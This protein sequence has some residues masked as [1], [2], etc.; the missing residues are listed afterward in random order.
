MKIQEFNQKYSGEEAV[1]KPPISTGKIK[2]IQEFN[3]KYEGFKKTE[4]VKPLDEKK[5]V[6]EPLFQKQPGVVGMEGLP[7]EEY[8]GFTQ[9]AGGG[10]PFDFHIATPKMSVKKA[11]LGLGAGF[12]VVSQIVE[13]VTNRLLDTADFGYDFVDK[14]KN[15][16]LESKDFVKAG[17]KALNVPLA[18]LHLAFT[19]ISASLATAEASGVPIISQAGFLTNKAFEYLGMAGGW[20][21][22]KIIEALPVSDETKKIFMEPAVEI[23]N[24]ALPLLVGKLGPKALQNISERTKIT[25][26]TMTAPEGGKM[27]VL[28]QE[29]TIPAKI[30]KVAAP[31]SE[32]MI[33]PFG[34]TGRAIS[35][36]I[37]NKVRAYQKAGK[38]VN[39]EA[40]QKIVRDAVREV[41]AEV[42]G[43]AEIRRIDEKGKEAEPIV[44]DTKHKLVLQNIIP[45][46]ED[47]NWKKV[48]DL[49]RDVDGR[50]INARYEFD[51]KNKTGTILY[52][53]R[54]QLG[55]MVH[56]FGHHFDRK[57][58]SEVGQKFSE[59]LGA[60][61]PTETN[62]NI[63]EFVISKLGGSA[64]KKQIDMQARSLAANFDKQITRLSKGETRGRS[65]RF[66]EAVS[67]VITD[68]AGAKKR[69]PEFTAFVEFA[70]AKGG[71]TA[72]KIKATAGKVKISIEAAPKVSVQYGNIR[73]YIMSRTNK[74]RT[75]SREE[76]GQEYLGGY[77]D[78]V[79]EVKKMGREPIS[80]EQWVK[81]KGIQDLRKA[82]KFRTSEE[83]TTKVLKWIGDRE[84]V[85][86][87]FI[88]DLTNRPELK[89]VER[90]LIRQVLETYKIKEENIKELIPFKEVRNMKIMPIDQ[91]IKKFDQTGSVTIAEDKA[92]GLR[93]VAKDEGDYVV[94]GV[95]TGKLIDTEL[96]K[97]FPER[98]FATKEEAFDFVRSLSEK[99]KLEAGEEKINAKEFADKVK[100]ELLPLTVRVSSDRFVRPSPKEAATGM[101]KIPKGSFRSKHEGISLPEEV[102]GN[103]ANYQERIYESPIKTSAGQT[104][105]GGATENYFG[106]TRIEDMGI[107]KTK[108][109]KAETEK[110]NEY[111]ITR[112]KEGGERIR[113]VIEV[114]S[115]LYQKGNLD[116]SISIK[117][118]TKNLKQLRALRNLLPEGD[119]PVER[120]FK[121]IKTAR[122]DLIKELG[123]KNLEDFKKAVQAGEEAILNSK[124]YQ[125]LQQYND[126]TAHFRMVR[127]EIKQAA[128]DGKT[129]LQFPTGETIMKIEG[130]GEITRWADAKTLEPLKINKLEI[131]RIVQ[132]ESE[133][134]ERGEMPDTNSWI[135]TD[136]LGDG[137]F[138]AVQK[139]F[140]ENHI[141]DYSKVQMNQLA[142]T[143][144]ISGKVDTSDPIYKFYEKDL[145][146]YLQSK[147][148]AKL[149]TDPQGVTWWEVNIKP[150]YGR[151]PVEA[152]RT[153]TTERPIDEKSLAEADR[154]ELLKINK[155]IFGD[156]NLAIVNQILTPEGQRALGSYRDSMIKIIDGKASA[157]DTLY[158][159]AVHKYFD[160][161][162]TIEEQVG[163]LQEGVK[164]Y[165]I[166]DLKQVEEKIAEDFIKYAKSREGITGKLKVIFDSVINR[167]NSFLDNEDSI[168]NFYTKILEGKKPAARFAEPGVE[169]RPGPAPFKGKPLTTPAI[170]FDKIN[171]PDDVVAAMKDVVEKNA[172]FGAERRKA[173]LDE[174]KQFSM[175]YLGDQNLY[176]NVPSAIREN[177]GMMKAAEQTMVD[178]A[179]DLLGK[180]KETDMTISTPEQFASL[181]DKFLKLEQ[182]T[183]S[184]AGSRTEA[185]HLLASLKSPVAPGENA[186][187]AELFGEMKRA[188]LDTGKVEEF[189]KI[190]NKAKEPLY[191]TRTEALVGL[192]INGLISGG[193]TMLKNITSTAGN[194][195]AEILARGLTKPSE[196][197]DLLM[198]IWNSL[199]EG[200][201]EAKAIVKGEKTSPVEKYLERTKKIPYEFKTAFGKKFANTIKYAGRIMG[202]SDAVFNTA[203]KRGEMASM[204]GRKIN[205]KDRGIIARDIAKEEGYRGKEL[206]MK[207]AEYKNNDQKLMEGAADEFAFRGTY[208]SDPKG[209]LGVV[210]RAIGSATSQRPILKLVQPFVRVVANVAN[211]MLDWSPYGF[212]RIKRG[213]GIG[214]I[215]AKEK[216]K[217]RELTSREK[218]QQLGRAIGGTLIFA[219]AAAMAAD[220][221]ISGTGPS[222]YNKRRQLEMTGWRQNAIKIGNRWVP[223]MNWGPVAFALSVA[224]NFY[225]AMEYGK[226]DEKS[227]LQRVEAAIVG[228]GQTFFQMSFLTGTS[229][230]MDLA[231][232]GNVTQWENYVARAATSLF[233]PNFIK[234]AI[235]IFDRNVYQPKNLWE[236]VIKNMGVAGIF[237][238]KPML[239]IFGEP[240][241]ADM[242]YGFSFGPTG[243]DIDPVAKFLGENK[244]WVSTPSKTTEIWVGD[245]KRP[246][247]DDEYYQYIKESGPIIKEGIKQEME[248]ISGQES[249]E[250]KQK[251]L[252]KIVD[253]ARKEIKDKIENEQI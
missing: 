58:A 62:I 117:G 69:A 85:S 118:G 223:Y 228:S 145:G 235:K 3:Q 42:K 93:M 135:I 218:T 101:A 31:V 150:E 219:A 217:A 148:G 191:E 239:N 110:G 61:S 234:Q 47:L 163:I 102:R 116:I 32:F 157:K 205:D 209:L 130:L 207:I 237:G 68:P 1:V 96:A 134:A 34:K 140:Y 97:E 60:A 23:G 27:T 212:V 45:G 165:G 19:P 18:A 222:D 2:T 242:A 184:F 139:G 161:M 244:L 174:M 129:K 105:F 13:G 113:R 53:Q 224:G 170:N 152:F 55:R 36:A 247:T 10:S 173:T 176:K 25:E 22:G 100:M 90:D 48:P 72:R 253:N 83:L 203:L 6:S 182:V 183:A 206:E 57:L 63:A 215:G 111:E 119:Y 94:V 185:S 103:V 175:K 84:T 190:K 92:R 231:Q 229:D 79:A 104:H 12:N 208:N 202:A 204:E 51:F 81:Y 8:V 196:V 197:P 241:K 56:E 33:D 9:G 177:I 195:V 124:E 88:E 243:K 126:P 194:G 5:P 138:K 240:V 43:T 216:Y 115:D 211:V 17:A 49:G 230:F 26:K 238:V 225:D 249:P 214:G 236:G 149:V 166:N 75:G 114:Q 250:E 136:V 248:Y 220:G 156:E 59:V 74:F 35:I 30:A 21:A 158:H 164:K 213:E 122:P 95:D 233:E 160:V 144:D 141:K 99:P 154:K 151:E 70:L 40:A 153:A 186:I 201:A 232:T 155:K 159:E 109:V 179:S 89:Q 147:Y 125:K 210:S 106:H 112:A 108:I 37:R 28:G 192:Y 178:M 180:L 142:E 67:K 162:T 200:F 76:I 189:F 87:Q 14:W 128:I 167:I 169:I 245:K 78:Y 50:K 137:K 54:S 91:A 29:S 11:P 246:M 77:R 71:A 132:R 52:T 199:P 86:R 227:A 65:E 181:R 168:K 82:E 7:S 64:T 20:A 198:G 143:F 221:R 39:A 98:M 4:V 188:G 193:W 146:K 107:S 226:L 121:A 46:M 73:D 24:V 171:A 123:V 41:P 187:L 15:N 172:Q 127:E 252:Q 131:G 44:I 80:F 251:V 66:A 120:S 133:F 38:E 16:A